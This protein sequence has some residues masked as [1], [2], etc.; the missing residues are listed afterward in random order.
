MA[1]AQAVCNSFKQQILEGIHDFESGGDVFK[2]SLYTSAANLSA[3][4]TVY[5]STNEVGDTGQYAAGG[6]T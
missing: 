6:G 3:S 1:I 2:L 4:A 5:T